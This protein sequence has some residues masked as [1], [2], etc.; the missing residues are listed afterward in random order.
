MSTWLQ[1]SH[2]CAVMELAATSLDLAAGAACYITHHSQTTV[3]ESPICLGDL[4]A[5][6]EM[7]GGLWWHSILLSVLAP[8][9][10]VC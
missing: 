2:I 6:L 10:T 8:L 7:Q 4:L 9:E 5:F 1:Q 3:A